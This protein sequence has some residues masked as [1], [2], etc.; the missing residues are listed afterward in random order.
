MF[1]KPDL[2]HQALLGVW[3]ES[4]ACVTHFDC[5]SCIGN[6]CMEEVEISWMHRKGHLQYVSEFVNG[7]TQYAHLVTLL[8]S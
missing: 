5:S 6:T 7:A 1:I 3:Y 8:K 2:Q 4:G